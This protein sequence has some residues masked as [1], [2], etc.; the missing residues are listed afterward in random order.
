MS[1][2]TSYKHLLTPKQYQVPI[3]DSKQGHL[4]CPWSP[5]CPGLQFDMRAKRS[6]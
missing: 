3:M 4:G 1:P 6:L 2:S 5:S